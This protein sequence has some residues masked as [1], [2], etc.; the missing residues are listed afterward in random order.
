MKCVISSTYDSK[1]LYFLPIVTFCWNK[2][3]VDVICFMPKF[4]EGHDIG[5]GEWWLKKSALVHKV[6]VNLCPNTRIAYFHCQD[7][8]Q[9]TYAQ[10]SRL[11]AACLNL[12]EDEQLVVSDID[13]IFFKKDYIL[14]AVNGIIDVYGA[15][16]VP[17]LQYPMCYLSGSV[18]TWRDLVGDGTYQEHLDNLLGKIEC[19]SFRGNYWGKD[20]EE[21]YR[22]L[23]FSDSVDYSLHN[24]AKP[25]TQFATNRYDRDDAFLLDRLSLDTIDYHLPRPG[26]EENNFN[27][28]L[29]VLTFHYPQEDFTW[30]INYRNE[31]LKLL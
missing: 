2:L 17:L 15:D 20:Q 27:Q 7:N 11:Y 6:T 14:P 10:C 9:S 26:Y 31:Y 13:M 23:Q 16:L 22:L 8:K 12:P 3:G 24:R 28:I 30:L 1:Y 5:G 29:S 21:I 4:A 18:K 19:E 25:G